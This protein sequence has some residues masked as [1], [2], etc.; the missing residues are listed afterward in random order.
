MLVKYEWVTPQIGVTRAT[1][2]FYMKYEAI[3]SDICIVNIRIQNVGLCE[4]I[5]IE[6]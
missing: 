6:C 5:N 3:Q 2:L 4:E 1:K